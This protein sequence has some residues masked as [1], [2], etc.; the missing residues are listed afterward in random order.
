[1]H[2]KR[3]CIY[4]EDVNISILSNQSKVMKIKL[5]ALWCPSLSPGCYITQSA[6]LLDIDKNQSLTL[7]SRG[8]I[9]ILLASALI[10][11]IKMSQTFA[12]PF[13][14]IMLSFSHQHYWVAFII[15]GYFSDME[16]EA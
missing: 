16:T 4:F 2:I 11:L 8:K 7:Q 13:T 9:Q 6:L 14:F 10:C 12:I 3:E 1:M 15:L 5:I